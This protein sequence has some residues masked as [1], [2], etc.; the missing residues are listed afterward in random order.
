MRT[1][2]WAV[3][4]HYSSELFYQYS[5]LV[6]AISEDIARDKFYQTFPKLKEEKC[7][8]DKII[9]VHGSVRESEE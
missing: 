3:I 9:Y 1:Y 2:L 5:T 8:I 6:R 7:I 4:Y